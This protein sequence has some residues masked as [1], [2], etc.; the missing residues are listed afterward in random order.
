MRID[1]VVLDFCKSYDRIISYGAG[2][3]AASLYYFLQCYKVK[4]SDSVVS[5]KVT[6]S[7][8]FMKSVRTYSI[9]D[10]PVI[11]GV[12]YGIILALHPRHHEEVLE[13]IKRH[14]HESVGILPLTMQ[15]AHELYNYAQNIWRDDLLHE[16]DCLE[17]EETASFE[18]RILEIAK[19]YK[20]IRL[21]YINAYTIGAMGWS[22]IRARIERE[23]YQD[24]RFHLYY[25]V[26]WYGREELDSPNNA[27]LYHATAPG[28]EII[29]KRNIK[30]WRYFL[31]K[32]REIFKISDKYSLANDVESFCKFAHKTVH[33]LLNEFI[34][35]TYKEK[36]E[37]EKFCKQ[38]M[39]LRKPFV[40]F[41]AR[42]SLYVDTMRK[43]PWEQ[44]VDF[45][46][47]VRNSRLENFKL[48]MENLGEDG[49]QTIRMGATAS[50]AITWKNT[51]DYAY[52]YRDEFLDLYLCSRCLF[53]VSNM[54]GIQAIPQLFTK[55][56]VAVDVPFLTQRGDYTLFLSRNRD[57]AIY[58]KYWYE[59][60]KRYLTF[61]EM[62]LYETDDILLNGVFNTAK[63]YKL[64]GITI[65]DNTPEEIDDVV[66]EM[67]A[68]IHG[69]MEY[70]T[71]DETLQQRFFDIIDSFPMKKNYPFMFRVGAKFLRQN[72]W[73]LD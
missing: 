51:I 73:L 20:S 70:T 39:H 62:L 46:N 9:S 53:F 48:A 24:E 23:L 8:M 31:M 5:G 67:Y 41:C 49:I 59:K 13:R 64:M 56:L 34:S 61:K 19:S 44:N 27:L 54:S 57:L 7:S 1:K 45:I 65:V 16:K 38:V 35:F 4:L 25:P 58:K 40:A 21:E 32:R 42:D 60:E 6:K 52:N 33:M 66:Q 10:Y 22:W 11:Y 71:E 2:F 17:R 47:V 15:N 14:F 28:I 26:V 37:A 12:R 55:P 50:G 36:I 3:E 69:T 72:A 68:R 18:D 63:E 30:F 43:K 29:S